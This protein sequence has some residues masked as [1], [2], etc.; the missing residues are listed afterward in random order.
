M[1][2]VEAIGELPDGPAVNPQDEW[3]FPGRVETGRLDDPG[4]DR[5][6]VGAFEPHSLARIEVEPSDM[7]RIGSAE[8][9]HGA[10]FNR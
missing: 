8:A 3:V 7:V 10:F 4:V 5:W 9:A 2:Q 1:R 6:S